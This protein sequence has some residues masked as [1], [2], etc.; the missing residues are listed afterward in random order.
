[1]DQS[2]LAGLGNLLVDE[3]L[4]RTGLSPLRPS[5]AMGN[6]QA[7]RLA[8]GVRGTVEDLLHRGGSH[9]GDLMDERRRGGV[10]PIDGEPLRRQEVGGRTTYWCP[11]HQ[12]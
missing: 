5:G 4:W 1:L 3:I 2:R 10:C 8:R 9:T 12:G 7:R 6:E 11:R